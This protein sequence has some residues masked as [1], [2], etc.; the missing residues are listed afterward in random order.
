MKNI[1]VNTIKKNDVGLTI[2]EED[3]H[4]S[5]NGIFI[6]VGTDITIPIGEPYYIPNANGTY[7]LHCTSG[8][9]VIWSIS[10]YENIDLDGTAEYTDIKF[11]IIDPSKPSSITFDCRA[12]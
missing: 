7:T 4:G 9:R 3:L 10:S 8:T 11:D 6:I 5:D 2:L 12:H 1:L